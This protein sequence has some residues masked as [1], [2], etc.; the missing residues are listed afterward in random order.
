[1]LRLRQRLCLVKTLSAKELNQ[2]VD[3]L[4]LKEPFRILTRLGLES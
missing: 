3:V 4:T 1:V 2:K